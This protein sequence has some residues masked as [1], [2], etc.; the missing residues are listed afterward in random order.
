MFDQLKNMKQLAGLMGNLGGLKE[1]ME[2]VQ[3]ELG[4]KA[5]EGEA[6]AGAV[7][8]TLN[9]RFEALKVQVD[10]VMISVLAGSGTDADRAMVEELIA[11]AFNA[12]TAKVQDQLKQ[13]L[14]EA[15]MGLGLPG[16]P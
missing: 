7:R 1:R 6:G 2:Q 15:A 9:G 11:S 14:G 13:T 10:P 8:V 5:V 16:M 4:A 3:A 12:A